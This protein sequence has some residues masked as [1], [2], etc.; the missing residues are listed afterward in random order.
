MSNQQSMT[1]ASAKHIAEFV[2]SAYS[3]L[4][5]QLV[6]S[7]GF[8]NE[9]GDHYRLIDQNSGKIF[10]IKYAQQHF[11]KFGEFFP[12]FGKGEGESV[13]TEVVKD[14]KDD[15]LIFFGGKDEILKI[16][17]G[18]LKEKGVCRDNEKYSDSTW[19]VGIEHCE[20][21]Y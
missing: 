12:E 8:K 7:P 15:D 13:S 17:V 20:Q 14:L 21:Y 4:G 16:F 1:F 11:K 10:H 3:N 9:N 19:S 6:I 18:D 5:R 2:K